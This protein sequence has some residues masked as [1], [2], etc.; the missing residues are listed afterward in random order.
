[1]VS[2]TTSNEILYLKICLLNLVDALNVLFAHFERVD[3]CRHVVMLLCLHLGP[4]NVRVI[5]VVLHDQCLE[6]RFSLFF[7]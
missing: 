1:M 2:L 7:L 4:L 6:L 3:Q 5:V